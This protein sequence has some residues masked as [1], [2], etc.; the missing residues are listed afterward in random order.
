VSA[1]WGDYLTAAA[2]ITDIGSIQWNGDVEVSEFDSLTSTNDPGVFRS[3]HA[4]TGIVGAERKPGDPFVSSLAGVMRLGVACHVDKIDGGLDFPGG[5][6]VAAEYVQA[7][8]TSSFLA[9]SSRLSLGIEYKPVH[10]LPIRTG[11][12]YGGS[13]ST[14]LAF[15]FGISSRHFDLDLATEDLLWL[16][17]GKYRNDFILKI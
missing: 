8:N 16:V 4:I 6:L 13:Q 1:G 17:T 5:L 7:V 12:S 3:I 15:G 9:R 2:S 11:F 14:H 10:W